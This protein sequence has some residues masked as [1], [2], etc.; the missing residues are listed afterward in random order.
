MPT[1]IPTYTGA[2]P[3]DYT[4]AYGGKPAVT[5]PAAAAREAI[6]QNLAG[7]GTS[8]D[9]AAKLN[10]FNLAEVTK[11]YQAGIPNYGAMAGQSSANIMAA[12]RGEVPADVL[13][14]LQTGAAERGIA[15]GMP[16]SPAANAAYLRALGLTSLGQQKYGEEALTGAVARMPRTGL[17]DVTKG[18]TTPQN[19]IEAANQANIYAAAPDPYQAAMAAQQ[20][21]LAGLRAGR[22]AGGISPAS[23]IASK[24]APS[25]QTVPGQESPLGSYPTYTGSTRGTGEGLIYGGAVAPGLPEGWSYGEHGYPMQTNAAEDFTTISGTSPAS[26]GFPN[27]FGDEEWI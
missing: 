19:I 18:F 25:Y 20:A 1:T 16:G 23:S 7:L 4:A 6:R 2:E 13:A 21:A 27:Y 15:T 14:Q 12:L 10:K 8:E 24:Y 9:L 11:Q 22:T 5:D 17:Y 3:I 26:Y